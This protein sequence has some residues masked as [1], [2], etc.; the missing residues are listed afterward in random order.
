MDAGLIITIAVLGAPMVVA[1]PMILGLIA[2]PFAAM[3]E[4]YFDHGP[5]GV[6]QH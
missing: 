5:D 6:S 1:V 3:L 2:A 4:S